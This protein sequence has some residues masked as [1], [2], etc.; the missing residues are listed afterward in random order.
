LQEAK[1]HLDKARAL[2]A[3]AEAGLSRELTDQLQ[4]LERQWTLDEADRQLAERL[5]KI[6]LDRSAWV[7][8]NFNYALAERAYPEAF[9]KAGL[10]VR[11]E[12]AQLVSLATR[13]GKSAIKEQLVAAL[14][15]WSDVAWYRGQKPLHARLLR[16]A[17]LADPDPWRDQVR[18]PAAWANPQIGKALAAKLLAD[19]TA[20]GRLSPHILALVGN[21]LL[22][23]R[24]AEGW[25]RQ[26]QATHPTDFWLSFN[27]ANLLRKAKPAEAA[28]Y[29]RVALSV[30]PQSTAAWINLGNA[31]TE[32]KDFSAARTTIHKALDLEPNFALAWNNLGSNRYKRG[33]LPGAAAALHKALDLE[34]ANALALANLGNVLR[35][36]KD[37]PGAVAALDKAL[38]LNPNQALTWYYLAA[39]RQDQNDWPGAIAAYRKVAALAPGSAD[40]WNKLGGALHHQKDIPGA[41]AA[42]R[43][44][45]QCD[46]RFARAWSN[47]G[48]ALYEKEDWKGAVAAY[49]K[50]LDVNSQSSHAWSGLGN[51]LRA[52]KDLKEAVIAYNKALAID[53]QVAKTWT[54][55][56]LALAGLK[57]PKGAVAA[58]RKALAIDPQFAMAWNNLGKALYDQKD[59]KGAAA[60][61]QKAVAI[62]PHYAMGWTGL[63][64]VLRNQ[65]DLKGAVAA[66]RKALAIDPQS[67]IAW[68]NLGNALADQQD[69]PGAVAAYHKALALKPQSAEVWTNLGTALCAEKKVKAAVAA[70]EKAVTIDPQNAGAWNSLGVALA[71][72]KDLK[73]AVFAYRKA[74]A[75]NPQLA[76]AW[77]NLGTNLLAQKD[78]PGA[79][80]AFQRVL[81]LRP[82][83]AEAN[84]NLGLTLREQGR[85]A[86]ALKYLEKGHQLGSRRPGWSFP[87]PR[88]VQQC[89]LFLKQEQRADAL[90]RG[91][92]KPNGPDELLQLA[93]FCQRYQR[94][95]TAAR[96]YAAAFTARPGLADDLAK[97]YRGQAALAAAR[98]AAGQGL[99]ADK[100]T[101]AENV[102][103]RQLALDWLQAD[104][105]L[106]IQ[107]VA[108]YQAGTGKENPSSASSLQELT[109]QVKRTD[110]ADLLRVW[111]R[112]QDWLEHP[113]LAGLRDPRALAKLAAD[114]QESWQQFWSDV[115][116]LQ[117][118]IRVCFREIRWQ[119]TLSRAQRERKHEVRLQAGK[120][121]AFE[122][123]DKQLQAQLRL[124]DSQGKKLAAAETTT[125]APRQKYRLFFTAVQSGTYHIIITAVEPGGMGAYT[126]LMRT[127]TDKKD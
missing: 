19:K 20:M 18:D 77:Y 16:V 62:D 105:K 40:T 119:G 122:F 89:R 96:L 3:R 6:H 126:L 17:R 45:L 115:Q 53:P 107:T 101:A 68:N 93:Q 63:G 88:W 82:E 12:D 81:A 124:E 43:Q 55:L 13:I 120:T 75:I 109:K 118:Q 28:G 95:C 44:A 38:K 24:D 84:C 31:L 92:A 21:S 61:Y 125:A 36:Q 33:D 111:D 72:Q 34:P 42:Y 103:L 114:E 83:Y 5:E 85:F 49:Q 10:A 30:R 7:N 127:F 64:D 26:A 71:D 90:V 8:D 39:M 98:A 123:Q 76:P 2:L 52:Q 32:Q 46:P 14:D 100:L 35:A 41:V 67:A 11:E 57:D 116:T 94:P 27:L 102:K 25:L 51:V 56:G 1:L 97:G 86:D 4:A 87:S 74:L 117:A 79:V 47:L 29:Y 110:P 112:L 78:L 23:P 48:L 60:A 9:A 15:D 80:D 70:F 106:L 121:Y 37:L 50:A 58:H 73:G 91:A 54:N 108:D 65:K 22:A 66:Y 59:L 99:D 113:D 104:L 69:L